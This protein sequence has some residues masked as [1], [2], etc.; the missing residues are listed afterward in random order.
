MSSLHSNK[1]TINYCNNSRKNGDN[2][3]CIFDESK[4]NTRHIARTQKIFFALNRVL[5]HY[6]FSINRDV[7]YFLI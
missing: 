1:G 3:S 2:F 6:L 5:F 4:I 7:D